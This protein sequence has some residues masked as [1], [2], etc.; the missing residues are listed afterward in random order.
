MDLISSS[1]AGDRIPAMSVLTAGIHHRQLPLHRSLYRWY[2]H[3]VVLTYPT[4]GAILNPT[5]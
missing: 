4:L 3:H 5:L 2:G 1:M